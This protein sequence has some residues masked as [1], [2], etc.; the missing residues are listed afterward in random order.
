LK[1][2]T[3]IFSELKKIKSDEIFGN[4][5]F[6]KME[7]TKLNN[8]STWTCVEQPRYYNITDL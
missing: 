4:T 7:F 6:I 3:N 8:Y 1:F 5:S 2:S